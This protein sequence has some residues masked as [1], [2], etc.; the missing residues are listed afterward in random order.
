M[1]YTT[2]ENPVMYPGTC[3]PTWN[4]I[5]DDWEEFIEAVDYCP[6][7]NQILSWVT[8]CHGCYMVR[9]E[10]DM[11]DEDQPN[12]FE[13]YIHS[14]R[15]STNGS[16]TFNFKEDFDHALVDNWIEKYVKPRILQWYGFTLD[17]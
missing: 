11:L 14:P 17:G 9:N 6:E 7:L 5:Y 13:I 10:P 4:I 16:F 8:H 12:S 15:K 2:E 3:Y 1:T